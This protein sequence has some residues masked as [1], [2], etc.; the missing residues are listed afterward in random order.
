MNLHDV[1]RHVALLGVLVIAGCP[2]E[3]GREY[4]RSAESTAI[5]GLDQAA[6]Q[7]LLGDPLAKQ[8]LVGQKCSERWLWFY[9]RKSIAATV[10]HSISINFDDKGIV[11]EL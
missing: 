9:G 4:D 1:R 6:V 7:K 3:F 2:S 8:P 10:S 5:H 11:C